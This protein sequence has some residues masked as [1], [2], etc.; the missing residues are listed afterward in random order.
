MP[1]KNQIDELKEILLGRKEN[2]LTNIQN[3]RSNIDQL[4][5]QDIND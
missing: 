5:E 3:S 2:I 1:N 4:K